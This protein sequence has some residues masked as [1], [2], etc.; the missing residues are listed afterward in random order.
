M[1]FFFVFFFTLSTV[2]FPSYAVHLALCLKVSL[3][4]DELLEQKEVSID[5]KV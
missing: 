1:N 5:L 2:N 4:I 3:G